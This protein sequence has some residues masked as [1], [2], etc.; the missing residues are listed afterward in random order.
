MQMKKLFR[1]NLVPVGPSPSM[2]DLRSLAR[3]EPENFVAKIQAGV[4]A[5]KL[6]LDQI[7]NW[8]A[9]YQGLG[10]VQVPVSLEIGG[11]R[12][13][14]MASAF[15]ILTGTLA[16]AAI[17]DAYN[18]VPSIG[19]NLVTEFEDPKK[20]TTIA[21]VH[22]LDK[23]V[24]E[25][26]PGDDYP[27]ISAAEE[28]VEI[29][30]KEN[31]RRLSIHADSIAENEIAD[32]VSRIN[33]LGLIAGE[34]VEEQTLSR[35]TDHY[36]S[37]SSAAEPYVYRPNGVGT[38]LYSATANMP[39]T[40][41][42]SGTRVNSNALQDETDLAA[43]R[44]VLRAMKNAR[45]RRINIPWSEVLIV[46]PDA[47]LEKLMKILRSELVPGVF[48]EYSMWGPG[49]M[50]NIPV[51]RVQSSPKLDD[52]SSSAWYMGAFRQQFTRKWKLRFEYVTL[53]T[54]TQA[55]L[56]SRI[57][58]QARIAWD[59]EIGATDYVFTI[60]SLSGTTAPADEA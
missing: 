22:A 9:L 8:P 25:I 52:L 48:N 16:I 59:V 60:Q 5:G 13:S 44:T 23:Q 57:A 28:K 4:D 50:F 2:Y 17:N 56:N 38:A 46:V 32:I 19:G 3:N 37:K 39:G 43:A 1:T 47:L 34:W 42:P 7:R 35:V 11:A 40:R 6:R 29:R 18:E 12:R 31:G 20:V 10:D 45:G 49:G 53:G 51:E 30:H 58:F 36:G 21:A 15:P 33:A 55:Y 26:K 24:D 14:I 54:D 27:E 41:A